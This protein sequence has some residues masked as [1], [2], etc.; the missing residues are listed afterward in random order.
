MARTTD[1]S[2]FSIS[3]TA[4]PVFSLYNYKQIYFRSLELPIYLSNE[5]LTLVFA[6]LYVTLFL[7]S[8]GLHLHL[9]YRAEVN[10]IDLIWRQAW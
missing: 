4:V 9:Y 8:T 2:K 5:A 6:Q 3:R 10:A 7:K 1:L